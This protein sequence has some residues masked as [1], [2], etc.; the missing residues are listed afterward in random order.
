MRWEQKTLASNVG[1]RILHTSSHRPV[2]V[3]VGSV[4][5]V[6]NGEAHRRKSCS[7][8]AH[9]YCRVFLYCNGFCA[10]DTVYMSCVVVSLERPWW[11]DNLHGWSSPPT[12]GGLVHDRRRYP[13]PCN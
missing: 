11:T 6:H 5:S 8:T 4:L 10:S 13:M 7:S 2:R 12:R 1:K 9:S 3:Q